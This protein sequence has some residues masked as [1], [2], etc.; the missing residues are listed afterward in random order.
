MLSRVFIIDAV[1]ESL[2]DRGQYVDVV[3]WGIP[4]AITAL[5]SM[6]PLRRRFDAIL[7]WYSWEMCA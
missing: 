3:Y 5:S 1:K 4:A 7:V 2:A 6:V